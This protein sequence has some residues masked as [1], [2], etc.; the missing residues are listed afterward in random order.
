[1][2][3]LDAIRWRPICSYSVSI[4][5][6]FLNMYSRALMHVFRL[7]GINHNALFDCF[8]LKSI[9][10]NFNSVASTNNSFIFKFSFDVKNFYTEIDKKLLLLRVKF[11]FECYRKLHKTNYISFPKHKMSKLDPFPYFTTDPKYYCISLSDLLIMI[12]VALD[13][14]YYELGIYIILQIVGLAMGCPM[15]AP[16][17]ILY[18]CF[19]EHNS[20]LPF[21]HKCFKMYYFEYLLLRYMD[22]I[23]FLISVAGDFDKCNMIVNLVSHYVQFCMYDQDAKRLTLKKIDGDVFLD[24]S[25]IV[26]DDMKSIKCIYYYK[27]TNMLSPVA[28]NVG[29]FYSAFSPTDSRT[30]LSAPLYICVRMFDLTS[31]ISDLPPNFLNLIVELRMLNYSLMSIRSLF[32]KANRSRPSPVWELPFFV[33]SSLS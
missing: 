20:I 13:F 8:S 15:S 33:I 23:I 14:A 19:D 4:I 2:I 12:N 1:M 9:I 22:D 16:L 27:N 21:F 3:K 32:I 29:R 5:I 17:A 24:S 31:F 10:N 28:Q 25:V 26:Y 7:S 18:L 11:V 6:K 30:K